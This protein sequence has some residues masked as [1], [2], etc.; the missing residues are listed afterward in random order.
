[1][2]VTLLKVGVIL[3]KIKFGIDIDGTITR[4]DT[5]IPFLNKDFGLQLKM[6]DIKEYDIRPHV[7]VEEDILN[8]WFRT[9]ES[10]IYQQSPLNKWAKEVISE[11]K[12]VGELYYISAR[13]TYLFDIT[14]Q[15]FKNNCIPYHHIELTGSHNKISL[16]KKYNID[17]FFEDKHDNAVQIGEECHIPVILFNTSYNQGN[18][19]TNVIRVNNWLEADQW[20]KEEFKL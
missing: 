13:H 3:R 18:V 12:D 1:M 11:W 6:E 5:I 8:Q 16:I 2:K 9:N 15:W 10:H 14:E 7:N 20:V 4:P 17:I 19:P